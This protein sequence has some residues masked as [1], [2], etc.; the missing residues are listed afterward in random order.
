MDGRMDGQ[1]QWLVALRTL[2]LEIP[3][4]DIVD[5]LSRLQDQQHCAVVT[6]GVAETSVEQAGAPPAPMRAAASA[7]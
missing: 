2:C 3:P 7:T 1:A 5:E 4:A 6:D